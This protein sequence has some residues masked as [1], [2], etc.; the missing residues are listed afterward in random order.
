[1]RIEDG[2]VW[3]SRASMGISDSSRGRRVTLRAELD[4]AQ[5]KF[6]LVFPPDLHAVFRRLTARVE[7]REPERTLFAVADNDPDRWVR[8]AWLI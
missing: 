1:M 6:D 5:Q 8:E 3:L 2:S 7:H 4:N